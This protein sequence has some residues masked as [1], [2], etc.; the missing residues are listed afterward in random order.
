MAL[1]FCTCLQEGRW[2]RVAFLCL[3]QIGFGVGLDSLGEANRLFFLQAMGVIRSST[4]LEVCMSSR[5]TYCC[6]GVGDD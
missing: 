3:M 4:G 5:L 6:L 1:P 2:W